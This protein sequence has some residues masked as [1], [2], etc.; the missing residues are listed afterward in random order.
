MREVAR[1]WSRHALIFL[2]A[3]S[4]AGA[5]LAQTSSAYV[6]DLVL[7]S[8]QR[9]SSFL[10]DFTYRIRVV[11]QGG[12]L[13]NASA[14][15]ASVTAN[16]IILD[17]DVLLG[18]L[19][20]GSTS[21]STDTFTLRQDRRVAFDPAKLNW[22][23]NA[24]AANTRPVAN[25]GP[26]Q[27]VRTGA[28]VT[29]N[30]TGSTDADG[31][32]LTYA[33]T[34]VSRPSGSTAVLS[35]STG[36]MPTF[37]P[38]RGGTYLFS[39]VVN[40]G[41]EKSLADE[42]RISTLNSAPIAN[43]GADRT[44]VRG[45]LVT[46]DGSASSDPDIDA[47]SFAWTIVSA[48][49]GST[50]ALSGATTARPTVR[51]AQAGSYRFRLVV[52]DGQLSSSP[53]EVTVSTENSAPVA[54]AGPDQSG[55][56]GVPA[57]FDGSASSDADRDALSFSWSWQSRPAASAAVLNAF[58]TPIASFVPDKAGL[59]VGQLI[60]ND[61][62]ANSVPDTAVVS[63]PLP[64]NRA[65]VA[66]AD[67]ASTPAGTAVIINVLGN[68]SDPDVGQTLSIA[69]FT[70]P[71]SGGA[72]TAV[73]GGLRFVPVTGFTGAATFSYVVTDG[74]L[75][76][77]ATV[78]VTVVGASN[79]APVV[80]AGA[81]QLFKLPYSGAVA[82]LTLSGSANDDGLPAP[83]HLTA[84]WSQVGGPAVATIGNAASLTTSVQ[85]P[86]TGSYVFRLTAN[87]GAVAASDD[88]SIV[89][90]AA[91]NTAPTL[92][93][94]TDRTIPLGSTLSLHL[95][96][97]DADPFDTLSLTIG[98]GPAGAT[99]SAPES[100]TWTP[101]TT[102]IGSFT[103]SITVRDA[104]G[105][106]DTKSFKVT[107]VNANRAP[108]LGALSDDTIGAATNYQK[109]LSATDPDGDALTFQLISGPAGMTLTG[110][111]LRWP[112]AQRG[113]YFVKVGV[114][115]PANAAAA[116]VFRLT[117]G[118][119]SAPLARDDRYH[120]KFGETLSVAAPGV[121]AND[122][123]A[124]GAALTAIRGGD[125]ALGT[126]STFNANGSFTYVAPATDPRPPFAVTAR[127]LTR[128]IYINDVYTS[129]V[130]GDLNGDGFPDLVY[131]WFNQNHTAISG[132]DGSILWQADRTLI[133]G[134][135]DWLGVSVHRLVA[136][137]DDDGQ[138]EYVYFSQCG[139][140]IRLVAADHNGH[141]KWVAPSA[142]HRYL[143]IA[144]FYGNGYCP[145][146]AAPVAYDTF[147]RV[148]PSVARLTPNSRPVIL[149]RR[150]VTADA[151]NTLSPTP[152]GPLAYHS[153]GCALVTGKET[154]MATGCRATFIVSTVDGSVQ[155]VLTAPTR[156]V[157]GSGLTNAGPFASDFQPPFT[158]DLDG[159][160]QVEIISGSDVWRLVNGQ[161]TLAWQT[162][163][164]PAQ[165]AV[166]DLDGDGRAEVVHFHVREGMGPYNGEPLPGFS[167]F[168]VYNAD[169]VEQR[170]IPLQPASMSGYLTIAD[171]DGDVTPELLITANAMV[172]AM[173]TEGALK[174]TFVLPDSTVNPAPYREYRQTSKTNV[175]VY[176]LDGDGVKEVVVSSLFGVHILD[177]R[178]GTAKVNFSAGQR[179]ASGGVPRMTFVVDWNND[180]HADVV[181]FGQGNGTLGG[182]GSFVLSA[183]N[184]DWLP[185]GKTFHQAQ[186]RIGDVDD[187]GHVVYNTAIDRSFGNPRQLGTIRDPREAAGTSFGYAASNGAGTSNAARVF[188]SLV[189]DNQ[190][191]VITSRPPTAIQASSSEDYLY[192]LS[193]ADPDAGDTVTYS[194]VN[195]PT[196]V[197]I[198]AATGAVRFD[199][200]PCGSYGSPCDYGRVTVVLAATDSRGAQT[201]QSFVVNVTT[202]APAAVPNV[203]GS[204]K[205]AA[206]QALSAL[207]RT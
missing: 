95:G 72:V 68:D 4:W 186:Y 22:T 34:M 58:D 18:T 26:D 165:V 55:A 52:S 2:L 122:A 156:H 88:V 201:T 167:G 188:I 148:S 199:T 112:S 32:A 198:S 181:S 193:A 113:E 79:A 103:F 200:G 85:L 155:Q 139:G 147:G 47:L 166:A 62:L 13:T 81:D 89:V 53:D 114:R 178:N 46:L 205:A 49:A 189:P 128:S 106:S 43:A 127:P 179:I 92:L 3:F 96:V 99:L 77:G 40:D 6:T 69:S 168:I 141:T 19:A 56:L 164:E 14:S 82:S 1:S 74:A 48:P 135:F 159:D 63:V 116:G 9:Y 173:S 8:S 73:A 124:E 185:A 197:S 80:N 50:A 170:R 11:N 42:V 143:A 202:S 107:V 86:A 23:I 196:W 136:D 151:G 65:P 184:N 17:N 87:D 125:P 169:G 71:A 20:A 190:P 182:D 41:R 57:Q 5:S 45:S 129:P 108:S 150:T 126:L 78:T 38:D 70:Q 133:N 105:L 194:I 152:E 120:V 207:G 27:T 130:I 174:W 110:S 121:L 149:F 162:A 131:D 153:Y 98:A 154:D 29:L 146:E 15:V 91:T 115:D 61:G 101:G 145:P 191:P 183:A 158:A 54:N 67:V 21:V 12:A 31:N 76:A 177:G 83:A 132:S 157:D 160:G 140:E 195:A 64:V 66:V 117:V 10:S 30:G 7:V 111:T 36:A 187:S 44:V 60:V 102:Q 104:G 37:T 180:G 33:W 16:T 176:D 84:G 138:P 175:Q 203:V 171:V 100:L 94:I 137:I 163:A 28:R 93:A 39:L 75:T 123:D 206:V 51:L 109:T 90:A 59:Y 118:A 144:C 142:T 35:S 192:P 172:Y 119:V 25:A 97:S 161:W 134:C 204:A 24:T